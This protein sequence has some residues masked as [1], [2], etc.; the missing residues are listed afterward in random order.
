MTYRAVSYIGTC[1][2]IRWNTVFSCSDYDEGTIEQEVDHEEEDDGDF[3][4]YLSYDV[5]D[6]PRAIKCNEIGEM[7]VPDSYKKFG[8]DNMCDPQR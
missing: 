6:S 5:T 3:D 1:T 7:T 4:I 2:T 8:F